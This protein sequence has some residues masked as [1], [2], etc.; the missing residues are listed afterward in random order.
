[1]L[2]AFPAS[3]TKGVRSFASNQTC[4]VN[5]YL[6]A[7]L[8]TKRSNEATVTERP[9]E[10]KRP[11]L[12]SAEEETKF[13]P[14]PTPTPQ[15][16]PPLPNPPQNLPNQPA[17]TAVPQPAADP[18]NLI[19]GRFTVEQ[20]KERMQQTSEYLQ[21]LEA[22]HNAAKAEGN[23]ELADKLQLEYS[24]RKEMQLKMMHAVKLYVQK[25][26]MSG[27]PDP[28]QSQ[29]LDYPPC[30]LCC[31]VLIIFPHSV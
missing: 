5:P 14:K 31:P 8:P 20:V 10:T 7:G 11:R 19:G 25:Q 2:G 26:Q 16:Q 12:Q 17:P 24:Q 22:M 15:P 13:V 28:S 21:R 27:Q 23:T 3:Q 4:I 6:L 29:G 30:Y 9:P 18:S 1:M